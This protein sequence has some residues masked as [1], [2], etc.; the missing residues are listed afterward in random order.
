MCGESRKVLLGC[1]CYFS[2]SSIVLQMI[3]GDG[4]KTIF[5]RLRRA[6][7][8]IRMQLTPGFANQYRKKKNDLKTTSHSRILSGSLMLLKI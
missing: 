3:T 8:C 1:K 4:F 2:S 5:M 7:N 6:V